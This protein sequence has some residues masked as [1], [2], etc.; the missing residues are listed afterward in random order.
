MILKRLFDLLMS[1]FLLLFLSPFFL[2]IGI[3]VWMDDGFPVFF[4]QKRVGRF[5]ML[6]NLYKFRTMHVREGAGD[7]SF[8]AGSSHRVTK[9][10]RWLRKSK[11][12]ELPQLFNVWLGDMSFVGPRPEV[13]KWVLVYP[14]MWDSV[15]T[16]MPGITDNASILFR[17]EEQMLAEADD[18]ERL[19]A[20]VVL[21]Q[22]LRLYQQYVDDHSFIVDIG[23][24]FRTVWR[25]L[26]S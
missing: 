2:L 16:I 19:Y 26:C 21:P 20:D 12:D 7:G 18:P 9:V 17:N 3:L 8:D 15:L 4:V 10:G 25:V 6:F 11:L 14:A 22:K 23:I 24:L 13:E 1:T 5:R